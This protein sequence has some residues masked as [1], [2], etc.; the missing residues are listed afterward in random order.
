MGLPCRP[1]EHANATQ[2]EVN[3]NLSQFNPTVELILRLIKLHPM[4]EKGTLGIEPR[5]HTHDP[6]VQ[7]NLL[8]SSS[9]VSVHTSS[10]AQQ[11]ATAPSVT[12]QDSSQHSHQHSNQASSQ[13]SNQNGNQGSNQDHN[14]GSNQNGNQGITQDSSTTWL[15]PTTAEWQDIELVVGR[16]SATIWWALLPR[17]MQTTLLQ[18]QTRHQWELLMQLLCKLLQQLMLGHALDPDLDMITLFSRALRPVLSACCTGT[19]NF[20][21]LAIAMLGRLAE[22]STLLPQCQDGQLSRRSD[23]SKRLQSCCL[24]SAV[25]FAA[26]EISG[27]CAVLHNALANFACCFG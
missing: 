12:K 19:G 10:T 14:Q 6:A 7:C 25:S 20:S 2:T 24:R 5:P 26:P 11:S 13:G 18:D 16:A 22:D 17:V 23:H 27:G 21:S 8:P 15:T 1:N 3:C 9:T 4:S